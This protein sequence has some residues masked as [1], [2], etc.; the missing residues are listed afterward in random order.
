MK[1]G[2]KDIIGEKKELER[3]IEDL[4]L[5]FEK[6]NELILDVNVNDIIH[7]SYSCT[8]GEYQGKKVICTVSF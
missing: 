7:G 8:K 6:E 2:V 4:I 1:K 5:A 3:K